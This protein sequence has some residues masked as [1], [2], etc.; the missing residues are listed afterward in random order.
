MGASEPT[1]AAIRID[2]RAG[3]VI[4]MVTG[5]PQMI[6]EIKGLELSKLNVMGYFAKMS[7]ADL[8]SSEMEDEKRRGNQEEEARR[9]NVEEQLKLEAIALE[10]EIQRKKAEE[11]QAR[12]EALGKAEEAEA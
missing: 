5:P 2:L 9:K 6:D 1:L 7:A 11:E 8:K 12:L 10:S 4:A 3:S